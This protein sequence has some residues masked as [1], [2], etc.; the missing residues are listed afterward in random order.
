MR[1]LLALVLALLGPPA[2][3]AQAQLLTLCYHDVRAQVRRGVDPDRYAVDAASL[4]AQFEW[5]RG[6]GY[7]PVSLERVLAARA[8]GRP[9]PDKAVLLTFDDGYESFY[10]RVYPLLRAFDYPAVLALVTSW[11]GQ[12]REDLGYGRVRK[13]ARRFVTWAQVREMVDS[14]LVEIASH[15]HDLHRGVL[16]NPQGNLQPAAVTRRY[17]REAGAYEGDARYRERVRG[18]LRRSVELIERRTGR[19]PR[20]VV[21]PFGRYTRAARNIARDLG[22]PIAMTL[23]SGVS[24][25][26]DLGAVRRLLVL[27]NPPL[28]DWVWQ[29]RHPARRDPRRVAHVDLDYLDDPDPAQRKANLDALLD[30]IKAMEINT[31]YLQAFADPDGDGVAEA[32]YFPNR[33]MPVRADLFNRVAWQLH[34]RSEVHVYA[35]MPV[36]AFDPPGDI[37][38]GHRVLSIEGGTPRVDPGRYRRLSPFD[39]WARRFVTEIYADLARHAHF[40]GVLF[41]DDAF[42]TDFEDAHPAARRRYARR[43]GLPADLDAIRADPAR[44]GRWTRRKTRWLVELTDALAEAMRVHRPEIETARNL[45]A[46]VVLE[47]E[48]EAWYAQSLEAFLA[49]Y[50]WTALMAMPFLERADDPA[51]WLER[52]ARRVLRHPG[53]ASRT[54]FELQAVNWRARRAIEAGRL[55]GQMERLQAQGAVHLGYYPD[56][57]IAGRPPLV[58]IKRGIS[59]STYPFEP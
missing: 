25:L 57:F 23:E 2:A 18:D 36:L 27:D 12:T 39:P 47:P 10:T 21:W 13:T 3:A 20:A 7:R 58:E 17:D 5:L 33:R 43:W 19:R 26:D 51:A 8:G 6:H 44:L 54:V 59:V 30:R 9:L 32:V 1:S 53:A 52:L 24:G 45:Y 28:A 49:R 50:D 56:D 16:G 55:V 4:A 11:V 22:M 34:T 41:H 42:L 38:A 14:G 48:S 40:Q 29:L 15:T 46:E 37:E 31:V 35:W